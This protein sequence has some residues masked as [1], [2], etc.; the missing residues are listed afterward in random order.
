MPYDIG[1][2]EKGKKDMDDK[3]LTMLDTKKP[4]SPLHLKHHN[5][6]GHKDKRRQNEEF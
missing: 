6:F 1:A 3:Y 5:Y 4:S 2:N